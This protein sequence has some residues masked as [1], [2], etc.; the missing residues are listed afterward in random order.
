MERS[1]KELLKYILDVNMEFSKIQE[2]FEKEDF[3]E[4]T[5][6]KIDISSDPVRLI[7]KAFDINEDEK[8]KKIFYIINDMYSRKF[9][10]QEAINQI[11]KILKD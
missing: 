2:T 9:T 10:T 8:G 7:I 3:I 1:S 11:E 6:I 4:T 5:K